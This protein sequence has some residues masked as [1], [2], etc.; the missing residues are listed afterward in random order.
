MVRIDPPPAASISGSAAPGG[1]H[2]R[3]SRNV[4]R[5]PEAVARGVG[6][7]SLEI[8][9][10]GEGDRVDEEVELP[11]KT[12]PASPRTRATSS[13]ERTS[14][15]VTSGLPTESSQLADAFFDALALVGEGELCAAGREA[16]CDRPGDRPAVGDAEDEST[17]PLEVLSHGAAVYAS[18]IPVAVITGGSSGI[19]AALARRLAVGDGAAF[20]SLGGGSG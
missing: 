20:S 14:H 3:V 4:E 13:S 10:V 5:K 8:A 16:L 12:S 7:A 18:R 19:G 6:E 11:P 1:R 9:C 15:S 17:F 2:E